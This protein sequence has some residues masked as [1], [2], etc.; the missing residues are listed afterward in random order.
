MTPPFYRPSIP[1]GGDKLACSAG[2]I[3][4][5]TTLLRVWLNCSQVNPCCTCGADAKARPRDTPKLHTL[6]GQET[7]HEKVNPLPLRV[8]AS[9]KLL[10]VYER[11]GILRMI[12]SLTSKIIKK[13]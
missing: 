6:A 10:R 3:K 2:R 5:L 8:A 12:K 13:K 11:R 1:T 4:N 9:R 7:L